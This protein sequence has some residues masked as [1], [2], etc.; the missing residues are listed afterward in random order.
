MI[1]PFAEAVS[2]ADHADFQRRVERRAAARGLVLDE[3]QARPSG[4]RS[5]RPHQRMFGQLGDRRSA[6]YGPDIV[7]DALDQALLLDQ[8]RMLASATAQAT[9]CPE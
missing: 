8:I 5:R 9:G 4:R 1:R 7:A 6:R 2:A 3:Q